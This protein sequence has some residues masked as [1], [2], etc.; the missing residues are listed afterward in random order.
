MHSNLV[1]KHTFLEFDDGNQSPYSLDEVSPGSRVRSS[2]DSI[3]YESGTVPEPVEMLQAKGCCESEFCLAL[4]KCKDNRLATIIDEEGS[5]RPSLEA[6]SLS[7]SAGGEETSEPE[8]ETDA[9]AEE[10]MRS[11]QQSK[12]SEGSM[13]NLAE[14]NARLAKENALLRQQCLEVALAAQNAAAATTNA[15]ATCWEPD[16]CSFAANTS[17]IQGQQTSPSELGQC[18]LAPTMSVAHPGGVAQMTVMQG[19]RPAGGG[20]MF[21]PAMPFADMSQCIWV[22]VNCPPNAVPVMQGANMMFPAGQHMDDQVQSMSS[23]HQPDNA[24]KQQARSVQRSR[25]GLQDSNAKQIFADQTSAQP[26]PKFAHDNGYFEAQD[27]RAPC[28]HPEHLRTTVMLRN[29]P[30]NY[31]RTMLMD[32]IDSEGFA[33]LYDFIYLPIDF[34]SRASLGYAFVNLVN[35]EAANRFRLTFDGFSDWILPSRKVCGV[36]WSGPHQGLEAHIERYRNSPVMHE[37]VPDMYKP[38]IFNDGV[39]VVF[40]PPTKKL[41]APRIRHFHGPGCV[42]SPVGMTLPGDS[43]APSGSWESFER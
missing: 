39:R 6:E 27:P 10:P 42:F 1:V 28:P 17:A 7:T 29:L 40:P 33:R 43:S 31:S 13:G 14:E 19:M 3:L 9:A 23:V 2:S 30:N 11:R 36:S 8:P 22:P 38:A 37:G 12:R 20:A 16:S 18:T 26:A 34:K 24:K 15:M 5:R 41:R 35:S 25:P 4:S 32:L 21:A